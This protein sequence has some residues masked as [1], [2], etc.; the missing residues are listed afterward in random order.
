VLT[1]T[2]DTPA[3]TGSEPALDPLLGPLQLVV[4]VLI[5]AIKAS[6]PPLEF[7]ID[8][9]VREDS[10]EDTDSESFFENSQDL[11]LQL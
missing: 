10:L 9:P 6:A 1:G 5:Q 3:R 11:A 7:I 2:I 8:P 4:T